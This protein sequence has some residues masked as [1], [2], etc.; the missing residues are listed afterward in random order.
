M[1]R[2]FL[3]ILLR[4]YSS[5]L[6]VSYLSKH[7][8]E[9]HF[10]L[11]NGLLRIGHFELGAAAVVTLSQNV[12]QKTFQF[13]FFNHLKQIWYKQFKIQEISAIYWG[14]CKDLNLVLKEKMIFLMINIE[15]LIT[16]QVYAKIDSY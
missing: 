14:I 6:I 5:S 9:L 7:N 8:D 16:P 1:K 10:E 12:T 13:R 11:Q 3:F 15:R 2:C 4:Y